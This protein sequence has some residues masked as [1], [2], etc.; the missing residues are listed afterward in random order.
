MEIQH[1]M[2]CCLYFKK[3]EL[4]MDRYLHNFSQLHFIQDW[5]ITTREKVRKN[6]SWSALMKIE[7]VTPKLQFQDL[8]FLVSTNAHYLGKGDIMPLVKAWTHDLSEIIRNAHLQVQNQLL[9]K[10]MYFY[11]LTYVCP[12]KC[13]HM[14]TYIRV[15]KLIYLV[16]PT[17]KY[18]R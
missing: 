15:S 2:I 10:I 13:M 9:M 16:W 12:H 14:R 5:T 18:I 17:G 1:K 8:F 7:L 3:R 11:Y 4:Y 6:P